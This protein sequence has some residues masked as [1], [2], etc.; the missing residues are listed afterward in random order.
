MKAPK[1]I[2]SMG[3]INAKEGIEMNPLLPTWIT[4]RRER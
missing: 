2:Y 1:G 3:G 4:N